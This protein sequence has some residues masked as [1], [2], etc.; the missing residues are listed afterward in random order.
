LN[1]G[2]KIFNA[3]GFG[4]SRDIIIDTLIRRAE[5][6]FGWI[7]LVILFGLIISLI[8]PKTDS[9]KPA[10][11]ASH[12]ETSFILL[13]LAIGAGLIAFPEFFYLLDNFGWRMNTIFKFY[14]Q[15]WLLLNVC[16]SFGA[17]VVM[18]QMK[19]LGKKIAIISIGL[20]TAIILIY[21]VMGSYYRFV[22]DHN[23][24]MSLDGAYHIRTYAPQEAEGIDFLRKAPDGVLVEAVGGSYQASFGRISTH[25]GLPTILGWPGHE[26]QWRGGYDEIGGREEDVRRIYQ[27]RDWQDT[28]LLLD[29]Y[30]VRYI[31]VGSIER[32]TYIVEEEKFKSHLDVV[33]QN[34]G[35]V[36]YEYQPVRALD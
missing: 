17:I 18:D 34:E 27:V 36:I 26:S 28:Q 22:T 4:A 35:V 3:Q 6:P 11:V 24:T 13:I 16:A 12:H 23:A 2:G 25:T 9:E 20:M 5:S 30:Q 7:T 31:Y 14:Y 10:G 21:P 15:A 29:L 1:L 8:L 33:F 19:G 32:S